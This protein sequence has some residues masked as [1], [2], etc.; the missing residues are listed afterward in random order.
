MGPEKRMDLSATIH[1]LGDL[2]GE[3]LRQR[4]GQSFFEVEEQIRSLAKA[5]RA[6]AA[7]ADDQLVQAIQRLSPDEARVIATAFALYFD[8]VNLAEEANRIGR[9][10]AR[11]RE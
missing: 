8:L 5:R 10:R 4:E 7:Q 11:E 2:L 9:L 3:V 1:L 6:G